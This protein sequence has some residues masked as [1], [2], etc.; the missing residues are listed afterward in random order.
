MSIQAN[1][2]SLLLDWFATLHAV[3]L[4]LDCYGDCCICAIPGV[5]KSHYFYFL[6]CQ[7]FLFIF[8]PT[9]VHSTDL[10]SLFQVSESYCVKRLA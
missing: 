1:N 7:I 9:Y 3:C 6:L 5:N 8:M 4:F 2:E 10:V